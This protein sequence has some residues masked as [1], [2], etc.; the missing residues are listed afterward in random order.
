MKN[1]RRN[2]RP[3]IAKV[4]VRTDRSIDVD[5]VEEM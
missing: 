3:V 1:W 4:L 5:R 2:G